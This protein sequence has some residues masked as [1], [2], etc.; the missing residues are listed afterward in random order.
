MVT[1][2]AVKYGKAERKRMANLTSE[3]FK[4][5]IPGSRNCSLILPPWST[6]QDPPS[7]TAYNISLPVPSDCF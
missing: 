4:T 6:E 5:N 3:I 1:Y 2:V 7:S